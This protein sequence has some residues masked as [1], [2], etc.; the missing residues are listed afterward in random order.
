[1]AAKHP[2]TELVPYLRGALGVDRRA[3]VE[4]HLDQCAQCRESAES[5]TAILSQLSVAVEAV[6]APDWVAYRADL[7]RKLLT[8]RPE[9]VDARGRLR[10]SM[11]RMPAFGW[12]SIAIGAAAAAMLAIVLVTHRGSG[13]QTPGVDQLELQTDIGS[14]DVGLLANYRVVEHLDLLE[15][16]EVIEH[17]DELAPGDRQN[18]E[19]SS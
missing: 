15:N 18:H 3:L 12:P 14:A 17:L 16:Y 10:P 13:V 2:A 7:R 5:A 9:P 11:F 8:A 19:A 4:Q 1:M 6:P